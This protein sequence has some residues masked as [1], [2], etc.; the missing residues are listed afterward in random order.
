L[1]IAMPSAA[2]QSEQLIYTVEE[3]PPIFKLVFLGLQ[4]VSLL[5]IFLVFLVLVV[6]EAGASQGVALS[7]LSFAMIALGLGAV[8]QGWWKG[9]IGSGYL[10]PPGLSAIYLPVSLL[11][12]REGGLPLVFGM[13]IVAGAFEILLSRFLVRLRWLF[14]PVVTGIIIAAVGFEVGLIG[15]KEILCVAGQLCAADFTV[16]LGVA[17]LTAAIMMGLS[18]W[19][20]GTLRLYCTLLGMIIGFAAA[21]AAGL[22]SPQDKLQ[23]FRAPVLA[24]PGTGHLAH[25][26]ELALLGPFLVAGLAAGVRTIGVLTTAQQINDEHWEKPDLKS[27]KGGVLADGLGCLIGGAL[28][29]T[30]MSVSP[31]AVG[32]SKATGAASRYIAL[33]VGAWFLLLACTPKLAAVFLAFP[34]AVVGGTLLFAACLNLAGGLRVM[35]T[36]GLDSRKTFI[37]GVSL[38]LGLSHA[39]YPDYFHQL[40]HWA[41]LLTSSVLSIATITAILLNLIFRPGSRRRAVLAVAEGESPLPSLEQWARQQGRQWGVGA[42]TLDRAATAVKEALELL[43]SRRLSEGPVKVT[44][45]YDALDFV[46]DLAYR[47]S[48]PKPPPPGRP[49]PAKSAGALPFS[50]GLAGAWRCLCPDPVV[51]STQGAD[52]S[53]RL[54]F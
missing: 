10:A 8:F 35:S 45:S 23:L 25:V 41:D 29:A 44:L 53:I 7:S 39:V 14:P 27:I 51:C 36:G 21:A 34:P 22:L 19:A 24:L 32:T 52:C 49:P 11:A 18:V 46:A 3:W 26:F 54:V 38:L 15:L 17:F 33:A 20:K 50:Q 2:P 48:L 9:P 47:G 43:Q 40:P 1:P 4:M 31:S 16:H 37:I 12:A 28:G 5:S 30:G 42:E 13:T 6:R